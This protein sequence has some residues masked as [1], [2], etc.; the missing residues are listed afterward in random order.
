[1][2]RVSETE[3][4]RERESERKRIYVC[5]STRLVERRKT[6]KYGRA[7][8]IGLTGTRE[9]RGHHPSLGTKSSGTVHVPSPRGY[10]HMW[11]WKILNSWKYNTYHLRTS[12]R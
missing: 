3:R 12:S 2:R 6:V 8:F 5:I 9:T 7:R 1:M 10:V 4:E 11:W